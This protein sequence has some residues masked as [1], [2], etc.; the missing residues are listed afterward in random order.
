MLIIHQKRR[1]DFLRLGA[2]SLLGAAG[3]RQLGP[4]RAEWATPSEDALIGTPGGQRGRF[5]TID[6]ALA[7]G[8]SSGTVAGVVALAADS[9][10]VVYEG[11][12]RQARSGPPRRRDARHRVLAAVHDEGHHCDGLHAAGRTGQA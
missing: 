6:E 9:R 10:G 5:K 12:L 7:L 11:R 2:T 1:R 3:V 8:V 4:P